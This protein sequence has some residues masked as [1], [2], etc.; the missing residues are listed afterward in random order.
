MAWGG[1]FEC[2]MLGVWGCV[3]YRLCIVGR[4]VFCEFFVN[5]FR[6]GK[7]KYSFNLRF[8]SCF[9]QCMR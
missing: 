9:S 1:G 8:D 3:G 4:I 6:N 7:D 2:S 5:S